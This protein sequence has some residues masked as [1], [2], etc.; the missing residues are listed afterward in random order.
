MPLTGA[1]QVSEIPG[2]VRARISEIE[3]GIDLR[4]AQVNRLARVGEI[5]LV[6][7]Y[8]REGKEGE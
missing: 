2:S 5:V 4:A 7:G 6:Y 1:A 3:Q 8:L